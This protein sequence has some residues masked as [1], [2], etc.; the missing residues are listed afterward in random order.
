MVN[1]NNTLRY[2]RRRFQRGLLRGIG[3]T[4]LPILTRTEVTGLEN[5]PDK[6]PLLVVGN[7]IAAMEVVLMVVYAPWQMELLG[8]GDIP[9]PPIMHAIAKLH[10]YIG[11]NRG[12]L[13]RPAL[14][15]T[16][17]VLAQ[18]GILG[19]FPEGGIWETGEK[20]AKRGV[21]WLSYRA[22]A[23]VLPIGFGGLEGA[24]NAALSLKR[25]HLTMHVGKL[26]PPVTVP[27]GVSRKTAL[28]DAAQIIMQAVNNLIPDQYKGKDTHITHESFNLQIDIFNQQGK[29]VAVPRQLSIT[30][31]NALCKMWYRP[32]VLRIFENDIG[33]DVSVL[34]NLESRPDPGSIAQAITLIQGY[35]LNKNPA[36]FTYRFGNSEG[37][38]MEKGLD[39]LKALA[40]WAAAENYTLSIQPSRRYRLAGQSEEIVQN[41]PGEAHSW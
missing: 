25:P 15:Q 21:A 27:Q 10:G 29:S 24:M 31:A 19:M 6:G 20:P 26:M 37:M 32:A 3:R 5:F 9:P 13:D 41:T 16:L 23:P 8:P 33:L 36:F 18:E 39:E 1:D 14:N 35:S 30:E 11:I 40:G 22:Q 12:N 7:H 4:L 17:G 34:R 28:Y 38:A 2:P